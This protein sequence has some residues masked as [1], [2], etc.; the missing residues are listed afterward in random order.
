MKMPSVN[1]THNNT[2]TIPQNGMVPGATFTLIF[3]KTQGKGMNDRKILKKREIAKR[4]RVS[5]RD[6]KEGEGR[7]DNR[8][9]NARISR[10]LM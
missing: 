10:K 8:P 4:Q 3:R 9:K 1:S 6:K 7:N 5:T 2:G